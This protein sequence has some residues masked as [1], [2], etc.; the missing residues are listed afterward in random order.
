MS[1]FP[2]LKTGAVTQLPAHRTLQFATDVLQ[3]LDGTEQRFSN[4]ATSCHR[5]SVS[6]DVLDEAELQNIRSFVQQMNCAVGVFS[7]TDPWDGTVYTN[8]SLEGESTTDLLRGPL[9]SGTSM[10]IRENRT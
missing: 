8:C 4:Y 1:T 10:I 5:W 3:F 7:F 9:E 2:A 6:F